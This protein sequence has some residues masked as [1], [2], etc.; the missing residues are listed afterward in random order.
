[1]HISLR[2]L[3]KETVNLIQPY[4]ESNSERTMNHQLLRK[5][6]GPDMDAGQAETSVSL[7]FVTVQTWIVSAIS[8]AG[9]SDLSW[10]QC[11]ETARERPG[12]MKFISMDT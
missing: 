3:L 8:L 6:D 4:P 10:M 7:R 5:S 11:L 2:V 9:S 1:M 12:G